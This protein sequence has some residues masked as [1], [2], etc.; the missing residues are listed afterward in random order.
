MP[1]SF[2]YEEYIEKD[3]ESVYALISNFKEYKNFIPGCINS[4]NISNADEY[5][6]GRLEFNFLNKEYFIE[7][8]NYR[9]PNKLTIKQLKGPFNYLDATWVVTKKNSGC[10]VSFSAEFEAPLLLKPF[11]QQSLIDTFA[12][13]LMQ[14]FIKQAL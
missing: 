4:E 7:S 13:K 11:M 1:N 3:P 5:D 14:A 2:N 9:T 6:I 12:A 8:K 10:Q